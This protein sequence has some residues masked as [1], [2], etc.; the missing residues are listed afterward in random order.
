MIGRA[1]KTEEREAARL[2][3][4][5][6]CSVKQIA[7]ELEVSQ[8]SVSVW[9]RDIQLTDEQLRA[10]QARVARTPRT[11]A[12]ANLVPDVVAYRHP[13]FTP[14]DAQPGYRHHHTKSK[15]DVAEAVV[16]ALFAVH[17]FMVSQPFSENSP[18]DLVVDDGSGRLAK[19]QVKHGHVKE[20][21]GL[22][23]F[24]TC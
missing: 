2:L 20:A 16:L 5:D 10:L 3:R 24:A 21:E 23:F 13:Q 18:Y 7:A 6:G 15:G 17:G 11:P 22:V 14:S 12:P 4:Q 1:R 8:A 19:I 9:V